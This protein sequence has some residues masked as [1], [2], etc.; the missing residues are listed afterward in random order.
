MW[1]TCKEGYKVCE[2]HYQANLIKLKHPKVDEAR[3]V[4]KDI[5]HQ[6]VFKMGKGKHWLAVKMLKKEKKRR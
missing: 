2:K 3:Q 1:Q 5:E 6:K 4:V